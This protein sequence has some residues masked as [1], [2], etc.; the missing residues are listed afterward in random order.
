MAVQ[1]A[2]GHE[3]RDDLGHGVQTDLGEEP[4]MPLEIKQDLYRIVQE[5]LHNTV[6]HARA[7]Q[8]ELRMNQLDRIISVEVCD[9]GRGFDTA[10]EFPG[11]LGLH[12]MR[13]RVKSLG[14]ELNIESAPGE[15]TCIRVQVPIRAPASN[16]GSLTV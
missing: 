12:S 14:G 6:K 11:H 8:V 2:V 4:D 16:T 15:G 5:A 9:N 1:P 3:P 7:S 13:E 10:T